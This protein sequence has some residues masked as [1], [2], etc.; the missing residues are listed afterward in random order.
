MIGFIPTAYIL[1]LRLKNTYLFLHQPIFTL[2]SLYLVSTYSWEKYLTL[3]LLNLPLCSSASLQ[4]CL[5]AVCCCCCW[6]FKCIHRLHSIHWFD[7]NCWLL[8]YLKSYR[9]LV[10]KAWQC[11]NSCHIRV[12]PTHQVEGHGPTHWESPFVSVNKK[13]KRKE[14]AVNCCCITWKHQLKFFFPWTRISRIRKKSH[15]QHIHLHMGNRSL[16]MAL[17]AVRGGK[18][19]T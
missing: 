18:Y 15:H 7:R 8:M 5:S 11:K 10:E 4:L 17:Y 1:W 14:R 9:V 6:H 13:R 3:R 19:F 2:F 12:V 16:L